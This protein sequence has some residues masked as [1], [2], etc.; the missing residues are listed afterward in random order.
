MNHYEIR[1]KCTHLDYYRLEA[2]DEEHAKAKL[3]HALS[4]RDMNDIK[5]DDTIHRQHVIEYAVQLSPEGE[6][7]I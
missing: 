4:T 3:K 2:E 1:V 6:P 5:L 7:I